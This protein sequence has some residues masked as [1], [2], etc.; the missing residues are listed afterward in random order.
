[1]AKLKRGETVRLASGGPL[2]TVVEIV[3]GSVFT[4]ALCQWFVGQQVQE[5][6]FPEEALRQ[7]SPPSGP[8]AP[9]A[10]VDASSGQV[11]PSQN[12]D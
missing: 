12:D 1:M 10:A 5:H 4:N 9:A 8:P 3:E 7:A 11:A 6:E 2:M